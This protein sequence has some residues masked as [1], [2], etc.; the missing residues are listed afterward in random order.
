MTNAIN[1]LNAYN[2]YSASA[3][4]VATTPAVAY[5]PQVQ[6]P[7]ATGGGNAAVGTQY[8]APAAQAPVANQNTGA[9]NGGGIIDT[10]VQGATD[11]KNGMLGLFGMASKKA[12]SDMATAL[13]SAQATGKIDEAAMLK[14]QDSSG[15]EKM[16]YDLMLKE[17]ENKEQMATAAIQAMGTR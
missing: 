9:A 11:L 8:V 10:V 4:P 16:I 1:P 14:A 15:L 13:N 12:D 7:Y 5:Q 6:Q 17:Q 3:A 2:A